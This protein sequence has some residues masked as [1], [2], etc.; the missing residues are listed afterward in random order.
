MRPLQQELGAGYSFTVARQIRAHFQLTETQEA[1]QAMTH[2]NVGWRAESSDKLH[3]IQAQVEGLTISRLHPY[4]RWETLRDYARQIWSAYMAVARPTA[5]TRIAVRYINRL[6]FKSPIDFDHY[7]AKAPG[8]PD[9]LPQVVGGFLCRVV[10]PYK[11]TGIQVVI[12]QALEAPKAQGIVP[13]LLDIDVFLERSFA[14]D[15]EEHWT[16]LEQLRDL[17]N[18]AF[19][20]SVT[21]KTLE[22]LK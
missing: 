18:K 19:F 14:T 3:V 9:S 5:I 20:G 11:N 21:D 6:E 2:A 13:V 12:T 1:Q 8:L 7:L 10:I 15:E 4:D 22:M 16:I 17:K